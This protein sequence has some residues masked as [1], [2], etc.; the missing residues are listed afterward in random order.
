ML[1]KIPIFLFY[2]MNPDLKKSLMMGN[3]TLDYLS[4]NALFKK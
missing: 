2:K 4:T 3:N 1:Q